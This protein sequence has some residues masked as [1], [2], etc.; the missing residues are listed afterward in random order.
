MFDLWFETAESDIDQIRVMNER[1]GGRAS[2]FDAV[3]K[4]VADHLVDLEIIE[5]MGG[6]T[7]SAAFVRSRLPDGKKSRSGDLGEILAT[8]YVNQKSK[9]QTPVKRLRYKDDRNL[10]MRGDDVLG[11]REAK[12]R[13]KVLKVEAKS[14]LN[15][16]S[17]VIQEARDGLAKH[18]G[19]PNPGTLGFIEYI[20]RKEKRTTE[21]ELVSRLQ[22]DTIRARD[23]QHLIFTLS[24]NDPT[25][26]LEK[27]IDVVRDG[28]AILLRGCRVSEHGGFV[29]DVFDS[30]LRLIE[31]DGDS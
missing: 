31:N 3:V 12:T 1:D 21:A 9:F 2:V 10:A 7:K 19:R 15:I 6:F 27:H 14:R 17:S 28:V 11:F 22:R 4:T 13:I 26:Y 5:G 30:C 24:G 16:S 18:R 25:K 20:L 8:E 29:K 23:I